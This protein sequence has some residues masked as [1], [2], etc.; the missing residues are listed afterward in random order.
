[1]FYNKDEIVSILRDDI[2]Y[3]S[4]FIGNKRSFFIHVSDLMYP[5]ECGYTSL[6][7]VIISRYMDTMLWRDGRNPK[8][9]ILMSA[10]DAFVKKHRDDFIHKYSSFLNNINNSGYNPQL[11]S[12]TIMQNPFWS[13]SD[14]THR[15]GWVLTVSPNSF[16]PVKVKRYKK[17]HD[18]EKDGFEFL[19]KKVDNKQINIF[20][21][22]YSSLRKKMRCD[23]LAYFV[24]DELFDRLKDKVLIE[25]ERVGKVVGI[26]KGIEF[27]GDKN[28]VC[29]IRFILNYQDF[30]YKRNKLRSRIVDS[31]C[32]NI[33]KILGN[34][35]GHVANS[36]TESVYFETKLGNDANYR[37]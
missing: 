31:L 9:H 28:K 23:L 33:D 36:V 11:S 32:N 4:S 25:F 13:L 1:M 3:I 19:K 14:G 29:L 35:W 34:K 30:Y 22:A 18:F 17:R 12:F 2:D 20:E 37:L 21:D 27:T 10:D 5:L 24:D 8:W 6:Q 15:L 16:V 7:A 26:E